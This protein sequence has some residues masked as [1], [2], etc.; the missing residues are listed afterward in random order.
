MCM[1][2]KE[3]RPVMLIAGDPSAVGGE[4][5]IYSGG[6]NGRL[7]RQTETGPE[8]CRDGYTCTR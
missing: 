6:E 8:S 5:Q 3:R 1:W 7:W 2:G 4:R